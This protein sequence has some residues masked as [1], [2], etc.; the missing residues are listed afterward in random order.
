[1][2]LFDNHG[3]C[4]TIESWDI[5]KYD[6]LLLLIFNTF[7]L[8]SRKIVKQSIQQ[9]TSVG[10]DCRLKLYFLPF[11]LIFYN[12][13]LIRTAVYSAP[14]AANFV[15]QSKHQIKIL[16]FYSKRFISPNLS[17]ISSISCV[18]AIIFIGRGSE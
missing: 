2:F 11:F 13:K 1:M 14:I 15:P 10:Q 3:I 16:R 17:R 8:V 9:I 4:N 5:T 12:F 7:L 18:F 6:R